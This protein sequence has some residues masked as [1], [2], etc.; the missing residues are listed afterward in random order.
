MDSNAISIPLPR[1]TILVILPQILPLFKPG[2][3]HCCELVGNESRNFYGFAVE[4]GGEHFLRAQKPAFKR[5]A[6][7]RRE[8][9]CVYQECTQEKNRRRPPH[10]L[11]KRPF[12]GYNKHVKATSGTHGEP[13]PR[14]EPR[15]GASAVGNRFARIARERGVE[16]SCIFQ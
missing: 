5:K 10:L 15:H 3:R 9:R 16:R 6:N 2:F 7:A 13:T 14:S 1:I 4:T 8:R 11:Y 12:S